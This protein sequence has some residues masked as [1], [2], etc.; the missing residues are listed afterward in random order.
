MGFGPANPP[1]AYDACRILI[2][3][4]ASSLHF[5]SLVNKMCVK[6]WS[7]V[8]RWFYHQ[9]WMW[10]G[11]QSF[12]SFG[13]FEICESAFLDILYYLQEFILNISSFPYAFGSPHWSSCIR[14]TSCSKQN[15]RGFHI[16]SAI[17][18]FSVKR[19]HSLTRV[20][21]CSAVMNRRLIAEINSMKGWYFPLRLSK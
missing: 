19:S 3:Y 15:L 16:W 2:W 18:P 21:S 13:R 9:R 14:L 12:H 4:W 17:T 8:S 5:V 1:F 20:L 7:F 6:H 10:V 11:D